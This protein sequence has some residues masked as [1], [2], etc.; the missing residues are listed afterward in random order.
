MQ[1]I[2]GGVPVAAPTA[3]TSARST[4]LPPG[5]AGLEKTAVF[6][7][8][9]VAP[10]AATAAGHEKTAVFA[11]AAV[12]PVAPGGGGNFDKTS[13]Q[14]AG[15]APASG[16][17]FEKTAVHQTSKVQSPAAGSSTVPDIEI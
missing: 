3:Q 7:T 1:E 4:Q 13:I 6:A 9:A 8:A 17:G 12:A 5:P 2:T 14:Q 15:Q 11:T 16:S 10:V